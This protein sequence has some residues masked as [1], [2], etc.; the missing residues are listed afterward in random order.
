MAFKRLKWITR[1]NNIIGKKGQKNLFATLAT[2]VDQLQD[3]PKLN[4]LK[5]DIF[6]KNDKDCASRAKEN[7]KIR[8]RKY[9]TAT[10]IVL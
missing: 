5:R 2:F 8:Q 4:I 3:L 9:L 7:G 6:R 10:K 1:E